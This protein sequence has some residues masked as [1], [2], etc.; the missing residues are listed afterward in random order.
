MEVPFEF[1]KHRSLPVGA[2][3]PNG[4]DG[5]LRAGHREAHLAIGPENPKE[6]LRVG[7]LEFVRG[8]EHRRPRLDAARKGPPRAARVGRRALRT[9]EETAGIRDLFP[10]GGRTA[11]AR[12]SIKPW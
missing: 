2:G 5:R 7:R 1:R 3:E 12:P 6:S 8:P 10:H 4:V 9:L 11:I